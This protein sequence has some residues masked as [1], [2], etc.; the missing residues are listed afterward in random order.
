MTVPVT[1]TAWCGSIRA[2]MVGPD[3]ETFAGVGHR[4]GVRHPRNACSGRHSAGWPNV[5]GPGNDRDT[6]PDEAGPTPALA[7]SGAAR[8]GR[9]A[10][11]GERV[12][13]PAGRA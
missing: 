8:P 10:V 5:T 3:S 12:S 2:T 1:V 9:T 4:P 6:T 13:P 11:Q 7:G